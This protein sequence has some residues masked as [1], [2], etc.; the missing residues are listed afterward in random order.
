MID[1]VLLLNDWHVVGRVSD[2]S[3]NT[4]RPARSLEDR[5]RDKG[6]LILRVPKAPRVS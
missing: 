5:E 2:N 4:V 3:E 6:L 1:D